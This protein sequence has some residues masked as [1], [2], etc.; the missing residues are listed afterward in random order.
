ML[1]ST[2]LPEYVAEHLQRKIEKKEK[3]G[4]WIPEQLKEN[5]LLLRHEGWER[6]DAAVRNDMNS[7]TC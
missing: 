6:S 2:N 5:L 1:L 4:Y 3:N 7:M